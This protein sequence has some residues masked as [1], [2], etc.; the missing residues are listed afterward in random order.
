MWPEGRMARAGVP[1][2]LL[3]HGMREEGTASCDRCPACP[4]T[5]RSL[6]ETSSHSL[7]PLDRSS[8]SFTP[9]IPAHF[10]LHPHLARESLR[11]SCPPTPRLEAGVPPGSLGL[12]AWSSVMGYGPPVAP[13]PGTGSGV[14]RWGRAVNPTLPLWAL[15]S[16][17]RIRE[18]KNRGAGLPTPLSIVSESKGCDRGMPTA[19][20]Q[21]ETSFVA[22]PAGMSAEMQSLEVLGR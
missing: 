20:V 6:P 8:G 12:S 15:S 7:V 19:G 4:L 3:P 14:G 16:F 5:R 9:G 2:S 10:P 1:S 22:S 21:V 11:C 17:R 13:S 18:R